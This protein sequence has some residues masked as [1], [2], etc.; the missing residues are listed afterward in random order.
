MAMASEKQRG[1]HCSAMSLKAD[2]G[3]CHNSST[4]TP[5]TGSTTG[6]TSGWSKLAPKDRAIRSAT[7]SG[8][9]STP[10]ASKTYAARSG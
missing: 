1:M 6:A 8:E 9:K 10:K 4:W 3:P 5:A 2:V 7:R